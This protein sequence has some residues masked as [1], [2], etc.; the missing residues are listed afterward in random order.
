MSTIRVENTILDGL[1]KY[2]EASSDGRPGS[3]LVLCSTVRWGSQLQL[4]QLCGRIRLGLR[5]RL[6]ISAVSSKLN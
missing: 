6:S 4:K 3:A 1:T 2:L 5:L